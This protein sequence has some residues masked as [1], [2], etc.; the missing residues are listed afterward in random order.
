MLIPVELS[1]FSFDPASHVPV[2]VLRELCGDRT[3]SVAIGHSDANA[4]AL[5]SMEVTSE[6]PMTIDLVTMV[7]DAL[8]GSLDKVVLIPGEEKGTC[9]AR[10][11]VAGTKG[12]NII[13][14]RPPDGVALAIRCRCPAFAD[15]ALFI[16]NEEDVPE[17]QR[18]RQTIRSTDTLDFGRYYLE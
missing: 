1:T 4:I 5:K 12:L 7:I 9:Q 18:L 10:M 6:S 2:I 16:Q 17:D 13:Q 14:C 3:I 15:E 8:G 11:Y